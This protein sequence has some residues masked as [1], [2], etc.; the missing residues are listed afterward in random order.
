M[1]MW[2][3]W[4]KKLLTSSKSKFMGIKPKKS[5]PEAAF[6]K[7]VDN[8]ENYNLRRSSPTFTMSPAPI[9]INRSPVEEKLHKKFSISLKVEK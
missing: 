3:M 8:V 4:I 6:E 7:A 5:F 1:G 2:I 9:V